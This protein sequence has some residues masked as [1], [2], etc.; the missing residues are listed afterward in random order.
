MEADKLR[1]LIIDRFE[2]GDLLQYIEDI[3]MEVF[4]DEAWGLIEL[5][6][7]EIIEDLGEEYDRV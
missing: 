6:E 2:V 3:S 5:V 1:E 7:D 4:L